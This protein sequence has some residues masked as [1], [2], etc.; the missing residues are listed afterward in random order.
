M[1][2]RDAMTSGAYREVLTGGATELQRTL[3][4][5]GDDLKKDAEGRSLDDILSELIDT[6][7]PEN[8]D[9]ED[10]PVEPETTPAPEI[11]DTDFDAPIMTRQAPAHENTLGSGPPRRARWERRRP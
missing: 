11:D 8:D 1:S 2:A 9:L 5:R 3:H 4:E 6:D 7:E 10:D